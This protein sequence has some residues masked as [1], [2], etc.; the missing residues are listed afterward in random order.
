VTRKRL[1]IPR[2]RRLEGDINSNEKTS[3][4]AE[5]AK[6]AAIAERTVW[7]ATGKKLALLRLGSSALCPEASRDDQRHLADER[8]KRNYL[9]EN[10]LQK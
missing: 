3:T 7:V 1:L 5:N 8:L 10:L 9:K 2:E 4:K 6:G